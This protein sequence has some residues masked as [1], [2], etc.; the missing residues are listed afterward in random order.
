MPIGIIKIFG[1]EF[2]ALI[3][4]SI[5]KGKIYFL[6][7]SALKHECPRHAFMRSPGRSLPN[8][9][10]SKIGGKGR[11]RRLRPVSR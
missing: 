3:L 6:T 11:G 10:R 2:K 7:D 5:P 1:H 9:P 4:G 8:G